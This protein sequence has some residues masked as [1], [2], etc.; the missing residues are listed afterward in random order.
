MAADLFINGCN[1]RNTNETRRDTDLEMLKRL[2]KSRET[3]RPK[4]HLPGNRAGNFEAD[5]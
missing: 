1:R 5:T 3:G 4:D 2:A